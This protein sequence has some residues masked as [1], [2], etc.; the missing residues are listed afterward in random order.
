MA[1]SLYAEMV[2]SLK[3][4]VRVKRGRDWNYGDIDGNSEGTFTGTYT[5]H[6]NGWL[7]YRVFHLWMYENKRILGHQKCT[8]KS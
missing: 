4:G 3:P 5:N 8:F 1:D 2:K 6:L 7:L